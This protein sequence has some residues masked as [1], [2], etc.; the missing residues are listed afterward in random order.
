M[1]SLLNILLLACL[2]GSAMVTCIVIVLGVMIGIKLLA[3][4][5]DANL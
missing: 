4:D 3:G 5:E 1:E 2:L